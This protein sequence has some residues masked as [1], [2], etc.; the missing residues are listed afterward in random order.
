MARSDSV[1]RHCVIVP[2]FNR[3][4]QV[5]KCVAGLV[6]DAPSNT[7]FLLVDDGSSPG[8]AHSNVMEP[9]LRIPNVRLLCHKDNYGVSAARNSAL[10]WCRSNGFEVVIM[11]DSDCLAGRSFVEEHLRLHEEHP[12][13]T[14]IGA[15]VIGVG[16]GV[17]AK[18]DGAASW[19][20]VHAGPIVDDGNGG[21]TC[22]GG[23][24]RKVEY[25]Y[26]L[27]TANFS[28]KL[29]RL[30]DREF[31]FDE[32]LVTGE[33]ALLVRE[34]LRN[35]KGVY[36]STT[37][38]V[39][40][41]DRESA[42]EVL[43]HHYEWGRHEY[44]VQLGGDLSARCFKP[45]Y[46]TLFSVCF[47]PALPLFALSGALLTLK[48]MVKNDVRVLLFFPFIFVLWLAKGVAVLEASVRP[49]ACLRNHRKKIAFDEAVFVSN[50]S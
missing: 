36:F 38:T 45:W 46:R 23:D 32:R 44:F 43:A 27:A 48:P 26:H 1:L 49:T 33:D 14:C 39:L 2:F 18:I 10:R 40:H 19:G 25:P 42:W 41:Q 12:E 50:G 6:D 28:A 34:L 37:P 31:V 17:W 3:L 7:V 5:V 35:E 21:S 9:I 30:P 11:I 22:S 24:F 47:F 29:D 13:A 15:G 4:D 16:E 20:P 8:A